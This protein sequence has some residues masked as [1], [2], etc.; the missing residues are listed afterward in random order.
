MRHPLALQLL[1]HLLQRLDLPRDP[2]PRQPAV[3]ARPP[4][5][6]ASPLPSPPRPTS[7]FSRDAPPPPGGPRSRSRRG[8]GGPCPR[9]LSSS[10][11]AT[12]QSASPR[13]LSM[14]LPNPAEPRC[15][16]SSAP[17]PPC[18]SA[19]SRRGASRPRRHGLSPAR[20]APAAGEADDGAL[21]SSPWLSLGWESHRAGA[22]P[23]G[24][25]RGGQK[26]EDC[27]G[28]RAWESTGARESRGNWR[29]WS[30][31][32]QGAMSGCIFFTS[33]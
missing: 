27:W 14:V 16:Y 21:P 9:A 18:V 19:R 33:L 3:A 2:E 26:P 11:A 8:G 17:A 28:Q 4:P 30:V 29:Q 5:R 32:K 22:A 7:S 23:C 12:A 10:A 15:L 20:P 31:T 1:Q 6:S 24:R 25:W 13:Q